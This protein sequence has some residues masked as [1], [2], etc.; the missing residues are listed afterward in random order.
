MDGEACR[1]QSMGSLDTISYPLL[2]FE[3]SGF[4]SSRAPSACGVNFLPGLETTSPR[5]AVPEPWGPSLAPGLS[6]LASVGAN[7][8]M[9]LRPGRQPGEEMCDLGEERAL[10]CFTSS[11]PQYFKEVFISSLF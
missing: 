5:P 4:Q 10:R 2:P 1:L 6:P 9:V 7:A 8:S 11:S 3:E